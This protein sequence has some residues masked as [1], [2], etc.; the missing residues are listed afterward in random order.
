M[1]TFRIIRF[2][3]PKPNTIIHRIQYKFSRFMF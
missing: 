3:F 1:R 2:I